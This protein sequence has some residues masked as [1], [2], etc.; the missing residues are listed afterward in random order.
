MELLDINRLPAFSRSS[1][2]VPDTFHSKLNK[3]KF[4]RFV[5][6]LTRI[7]RCFLLASSV[8]NLFTSSHS[9]ESILLIIILAGFV[10]RVI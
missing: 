5:V 8:R 10:C 2:L 9:G 4:P 1:S 3:T 7:L 6:F